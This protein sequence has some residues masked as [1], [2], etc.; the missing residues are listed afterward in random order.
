MK[1]SFIILSALSL[2]CALT[3]SGCNES[4]DST[5]DS[6]FALV[7]VPFEKF[8]ANETTD[9][10]FDAYTSATQKAANGSMCYG[11]YYKE[12]EAVSDSV[13]QGIITPVK[14]SKS[15]FKVW[16]LF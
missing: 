8:F 13:C 6:V 12:G 14:I 7:N 3:L 1:K 16:C 15:L 10:N 9:G 2:L 11:T 5:D 4:D